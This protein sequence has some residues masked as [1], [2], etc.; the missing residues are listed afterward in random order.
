MKRGVVADGR[1]KAVLI[2]SDD[3][4]LQI[5]QVM[6]TLGLKYNSGIFSRCL[7]CNTLLEERTIEQV[8][9]RVPP[10][11]FETREEYMECPACNRI[12]WKGTHWQAMN[13]KLNE[14]KNYG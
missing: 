7:E 11:V 4:N 8:K 10:Y 13:E 1:V 5:R 9:Y 14:L 3:S 2:G 6:E 12:Y